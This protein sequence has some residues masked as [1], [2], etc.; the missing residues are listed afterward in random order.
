M[1]NEGWGWG[2]RVRHPPLLV[3]R[4]TPCSNPR[5]PD[6]RS[7]KI[8]HIRNFCI[9]AQIYHGKSTIADRLIEATGTLEEREMKEQVLDTLDLERERGLTIKLN[10]VRMN[11]RARV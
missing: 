4:Y 10:A 3:P 11:Y 5:L 1:G 2:M 6:S 8:E 7:V 9:V